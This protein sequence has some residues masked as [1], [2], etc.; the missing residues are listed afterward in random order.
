MADLNT[1]PQLPMARQ[2][3]GAVKLNGEIIYGWVSWEVDNNAYRAADTFRVQFVVSALPP[4]RGPDW[5]ASQDSV[6]VE[7][8]AGFPA[9]PSQYTPE[10]L[11]SLIYGQADEINYNPVRGTID[12]SGR[13][14]T[15]LLI[16]TKT[17]EH[18]V[19]QTSSQIATI[20]AGRHG[21]T[22]VVT[23]TTTK[24]GDYYKDD[25]SSTTQQQSEWEILTFLAGLEDF[26]LYVQGQKLYFQQKSP[27]KTDQYAIA[28]DPPNPD[29]NYPY[30]N[31]IDLDFSR[32]LTIAKG[33]SVEVHSWNAKQKNGFSA[34]WPKNSKGIQPGQSASKT[35]VYRYTI[36]GLTQDAALKRAQRIY[37]QIILHEMRLTAYLPADNILDCT[38]PVVVRGTSTDFDQV[39]Y[40]DSVTRTMSVNEGYRMNIRGKNS[41]PDI[42]ATS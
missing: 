23:A 16:D 29:R 24:V 30:S 4:A 39:Y 3:R 17:S 37:D 36:A 34:V 40:C 10:D 41:T 33:V 25:H 20:L 12:V 13:D 28:W 38:K 9:D 8:L 35:Q 5:F 1:L 19:N 21:L 14:L 31:A 6:I 15:A 2:P 22:P 27:E 42:E 11:D 7:I 26:D 32:S 18:F